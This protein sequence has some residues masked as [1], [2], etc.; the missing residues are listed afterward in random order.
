MVLLVIGIGATGTLAFTLLNRP[1]GRAPSRLATSSN[2][3]LRPGQ[4]GI[5]TCTDPVAGRQWRVSWRAVE[6]WADATAASTV[7]AELLPTG[8]A[9]R[10]VPGSDARPLP[11]GV[12]LPGGWVSQDAATWRLRWRPTPAQRQSDPPDAKYQR[13]GS[14]AKLTSLTLAAENS[15]RFVTPDGGCT[16]YLSPFFSGTSTAIPAG[17]NPGGGSA[18]T[19]SSTGSAAGLGSA[20]STAGW[21]SSGSGPVAVIGD[22][23]LEQLYAPDDGSLTGALERRLSALGR[24]SEIAGQPGRRWTPFPGGSPDPAQADPTMLDEIRG[25]HSARAMVIALGT[26]DAGWITLSANHRQHE[27]RLN[28]VLSHLAAELDELRA[29][30][31]CTVLVTAADRNKI[32]HGAPPERFQKAAVQIDTYLRQRAAADPHDGLKLYDWAL[33][34]DQ[35]SRRDPVSWFKADTIHLNPAGIPAY[36]DALTRAAALC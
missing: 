31:Q 24:Q 27:Q 23:L 16:V 3:D 1:D 18:S 14:L 32:H 2:T 13:D 20:G 25:L 9:V 30:G 29:A 26:N 21:T 11:F 8:F 15:P 5:A 17:V 34:A 35:H 10:A 6:G 22:S 28:W 7:A 4:T 19:I 36:A 33:T 12:A